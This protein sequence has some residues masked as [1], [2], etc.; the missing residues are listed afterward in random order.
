M[1][2]VNYKFLFISLWATEYLDYTFNYYGID[3]N[4]GTIQITDCWW[5]IIWM[6][7]SIWRTNLIPPRIWITNN[8]TFGHVFD[9]LNTRL[10]HYSDPHCVKKYCF[11]LIA[12]YFWKEIQLQWVLENQKWS[13]LWWLNMFCL[14]SKPIESQTWLALTVFYVKKLYTKWLRLTASFF[15]LFLNGPFQYMDNVSK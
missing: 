6:V 9:P 8:S 7:A 10:V 13:V 12:C 11:F 15:V 14:W 5:S 1:K 3:L 4:N 2:K